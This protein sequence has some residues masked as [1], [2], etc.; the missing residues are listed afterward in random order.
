MEWALD[1]LELLFR[2]PST[3]SDAPIGSAGDIVEVH[4]VGGPVK[5]VDP[6]SRACL[7]PIQCFRCGREGSM[8]PVKRGSW[9]PTKITQRAKA[10]VRTAL[11]AYQHKTGIVSSKARML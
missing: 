1:H 8:T 7:G 3:P 10:Q 2:P 9:A 11:D 6:I 5:E 4:C